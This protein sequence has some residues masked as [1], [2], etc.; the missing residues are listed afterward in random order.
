MSNT[1]TPGHGFAGLVRG[2][3][4]EFGA[5]TG[6]NNSFLFE[7]GIQKVEWT[8]TLK[9]LGPDASRNT[10]FDCTPVPNSEFHGICL[11]P[12]GQQA[13]HHGSI[14]QAGDE[15]SVEDILIALIEFAATE[16][17]LNGVFPRYTEVHLQTE[18]MTVPA[19]HTVRMVLV[20]QFFEA[21][22]SRLDVWVP[23]SNGLEFFQQGS[24]IRFTGEE[25]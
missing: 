22:L 7:G 24:D 21:V 18:R 20:F 6:P 5:G 14:Q 4:K 3:F 13:A 15:A 23:A 19:H 16:T 25:W 12:L 1:S 9:P 10:C 11:E 17:A 2:A 8:L